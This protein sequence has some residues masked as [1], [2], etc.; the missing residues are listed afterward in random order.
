MYQ[1]F[2]SHNSRMG[3]FDFSW[4]LSTL[5]SFAIQYNLLNIPRH[6][7]SKPNLSF[8][9]F[10]HSLTAHFSLA[11]FFHW[12]GLLYR[13]VGPW[14]LLSGRVVD[15]ETRHRAIDWYV[16]INDNLFQG[17]LFA[18]AQPIFQENK[19]KGSIDNS[20]IYLNMQCACQCIL[21]GCIT[22]HL[23]KLIQ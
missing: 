15:K 6:I 17:S 20:V 7:Y 14:R 11:N 4:P 10:T 12:H 1:Y 3:D 21:A 5:F 2:K 23:S 18:S 16:I 8:R 13:I 19:C 22:Y 9:I